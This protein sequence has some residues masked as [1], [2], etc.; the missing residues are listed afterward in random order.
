M[1]VQAIRLFCIAALVGCSFSTPLPGGERDTPEPDGDTPYDE[2][3]P[4]FEP[5]LLDDTETMQEDE[6]MIQIRNP[7]CSTAVCIHYNLT[8]FCS[9][10]C[11]HS[12][13]CQDVEAGYCEL[14]IFVGDP[15]IR[16]MY[17]VPRSATR[18]H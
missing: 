7:E 8:T 4:D 13:D 2:P 14:D 17:C 1:I 10:R 6:Y 5:C 12:S 18:D 9:H 16:G 11:F 15:E 3:E